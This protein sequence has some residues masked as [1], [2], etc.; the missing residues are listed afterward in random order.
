MNI[1]FKTQVRQSYSYSLHLPLP[2]PPSKKEEKNKTK[3]NQNNSNHGNVTPGIGTYIKFVYRLGD[4]RL[5]FSSATLELYY[6]YKY[7]SY[8]GDGGAHFSSIT[9][10]LDLSCSW[11]SAINFSMSS[12][13][14]DNIL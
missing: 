12:Y 2:S 6:R 5:H 9:C 7:L 13:N 1:F 3:Q 14:K 4:E 11:N 10:V 8:L